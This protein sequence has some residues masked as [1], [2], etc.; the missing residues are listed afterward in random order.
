M[1]SEIW[2]HHRG[3]REEKELR[4]VEVKNCNQ[5]LYLAFR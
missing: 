5:Y 1:I 2:Q 4:K 3:F